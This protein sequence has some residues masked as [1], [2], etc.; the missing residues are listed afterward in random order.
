MKVPMGIVV[1]MLLHA[2]RT[3]VYTFIEILKSRSYKSKSKEKLMM[4]RWN[5]VTIYT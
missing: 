5:D 2:Q 4:D 1:V 3:L